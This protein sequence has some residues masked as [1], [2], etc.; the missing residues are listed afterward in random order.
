[1]ISNEEL[2]KIK[3]LG[4]EFNNTNIHDLKKFSKTKI[5]Y[6]NIPSK[7]RKGFFDEEGVQS[8]KS[9]KI[10]KQVDII[11]KIKDEFDLCI[12]TSWSS[13][14]IAYL[15]DLNYI[16]WFVGNDIRFPPFLKKFDFPTSKNHRYN[17]NVFERIFYKKIFDNA[18]VCI[19]GAEEMFEY[20]QKF[21]NDSIR[22]DRTIIN[23]PKLVEQKKILK[24]K[25]KF[26][27]F[28]PQR[29]AFEKGTDIIWKAISLCKND[30]DVIQVDW[31]DNT[32]TFSKEEKNELL[33]YKPK[34]VKLIKKIPRKEI[35][36]YYLKSDAVI[37]DMKIGYPNNIER[38]S[39]LCKKPVLSYNNTKM[40]FFID[41][42]KITSPFLPIS[43]DPKELSILI[44]KI[45]ESEEFRKELSNKEFNFVDNLGN[46]KKTAREW[47]EIF[48]RFSKKCKRISTSKKNLFL[49]KILFQIGFSLNLNKKEIDYF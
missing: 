38:E 23:I 16:I 17:L 14:R 42:N 1:L 7:D 13:A 47:D 24:F 34:N 27:I 49:K 26:T 44:D 28:C 25:K 15:A 19:T 5:T 31:I 29:I 48:Y 36:E 20:L 37:G 4:I 11:N 45:V 41:G 43:K 3:I 18:L 12:V 6:Y 40:K 39:A 22:V 21:R 33:K 9:L 10:K 32:I 2:E 46:P 35:L 8:F 30:F